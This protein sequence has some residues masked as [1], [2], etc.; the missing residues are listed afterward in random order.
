[1]PNPE[2]EPDEEIYDYTQREESQHNILSGGS[3]L[4]TTR[5]VPVTKEGE[6][7]N[8]RPPLKRNEKMNYLRNRMTMASKKKKMEEKLAITTMQKTGLTKSETLKGAKIIKAYL[9]KMEEIQ[10]MEEIVVAYCVCSLPISQ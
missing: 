1:M 3:R 4:D 2:Y 9:K 8:S 5:T 7:P 6:T 10:D